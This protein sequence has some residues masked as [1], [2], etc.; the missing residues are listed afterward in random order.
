MGHAAS[1]PGGWREMKEQRG[2]T[3]GGMHKE[4]ASGV[5]WR[6]PW[7]GHWLEG[8]PSQEDASPRNV[9]GTSLTELGSPA[10]NLFPRSNHPSLAN[11]Q[12]LVELTFLSPP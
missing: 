9:P 7:E 12:S 4:G 2:V 5:L 3:V 11:N 10:H 1:R 6:A 8:A